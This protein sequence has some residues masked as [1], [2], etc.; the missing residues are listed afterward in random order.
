MRQGL[1]RPIWVVAPSKGTSMEL[2]HFAYGPTEAGQ[3]MPSITISAPPEK[4][5]AAITEPELRKK[6]FFGVDTETDWQP[7]SP[8][9]H[10]GEWEGKPY[11]DKGEI[12]IFEPGRRLMHT[13][14]SSMSGRPDSPENYETVTYS[15]TEMNGATE[16][17]ITEDN[18]AGD[19]QKAKSDEMWK[20]A[21]AELKK[22]AEE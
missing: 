16:V 8:I 1:T 9:V 19:E 3:A 10:R 13:H 7:G 2:M 18:V 15:L 14:W 12:K 6:W 5:W 20:A 4:V 11:E 17:G 21:L 22:V